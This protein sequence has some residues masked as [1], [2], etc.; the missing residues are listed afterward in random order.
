MVENVYKI[1]KRLWVEVRRVLVSTNWAYWQMVV[2]KYEHIKS[3]RILEYKLR[4][5][6]VILLLNEN[7]NL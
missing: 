6:P 1:S 7:Q 4:Q 3:L 5:V 2:V